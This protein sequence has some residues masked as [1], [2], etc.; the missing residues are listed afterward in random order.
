M[1]F[2]ASSI[3]E[4][5]ATRDGAELLV[6]WTSTAPAGSMFQ[7]Y[8]R[9]RLVWHGTTRS[10][11]LPL[12]PAGATWRFDVGV[13]DPAEALADLSA[14]LPAPPGGG[15]RVTLR[16][17]GGSYLSPDLAGF[18]VYHGPSGGGTGAAGYG[19]GGYGASGY[20]VGGYDRPAETVAAY[21]QGVATDGYGTGGYGMGGYGTGAGSYAWTSRPLAGGDWSFAVLPFDRAGNKG[22]AT[23]A[24]ATIAAPPGPPAANALGRRLTLNYDP[25]THIATLAWLP[26]E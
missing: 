13:V 26:P 3:T 14:T 7:L 10:V 16:W 11:V 1:P 15:D 9:G 18:R 19:V 8:T 4:A 22:E 17:S 5:T 2:D 25:T 23:T 24:T 21:S 20:G 12:P 6:R